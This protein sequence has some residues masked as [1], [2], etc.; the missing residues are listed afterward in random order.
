MGS[1]P[2]AWFL[3]ALTITQIIL[4]SRLWRG[5]LVRQH[6]PG[7]R[8]A[9]DRPPATPVA[10]QAVNTSSNG[11]AALIGPGVGGVI[12]GSADR[13]LKAPRWH[14]WSTP[15]PT[16]DWCCWRRSVAL[17]NRSAEGRCRRTTDRRRLA[18]PVG[19]IERSGCWPS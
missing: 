12:V 2:L 6:C 13:R 15:A 17:S 8:P 10:A 18:L 5:G 11:I 16:T 9:A 1:V 19:R 14:F 4:V 3:G 7:R